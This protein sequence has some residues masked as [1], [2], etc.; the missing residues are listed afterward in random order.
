M[1]TQIILW[2]PLAV[3]GSAAFAALGIWAVIT[4]EQYRA[5]KRAIRVEAQRWSR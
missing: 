1:I 4:D 3:I 2:V 5:Q